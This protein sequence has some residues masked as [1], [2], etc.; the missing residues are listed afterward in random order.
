MR[1]WSRSRLLAST[2]AVAVLLPAGPTVVANARSDGQSPSVINVEIILDSSGSMAQKIGTETR[3]QISKR[4][5]KRVVSA[6]PDRPGIN[7]GFR[8]YGHLGDNSS[9]GRPVSCRSSDLMVPVDGVDKVA[10]GREVDLARP[11]GWTPLAYS[12][13]RAG[14]DL[15][16]GGDG[17]VNAAVLVTD[18]LE[19]CGGDPCAV[20]AALHASDVQLVTHVVSFAVD[21]AERAT[22]QC[23]ADAGGGLLLG[24]Q[25]ADQLTGALFRILQDLDVVSLTGTLEIESVDGIWPDA[26]AVCAGPL[27]DSDPSGRPITVRFDQTNVAEV[28]VG[29]C[30]VTWREPSGDVSRVRVTVDADRLTRIRGA[31]LAFPQGAGERYVVG[32]A[33]SRVRAWDGPIE[34]GDRVWV[35]PG[36]YVVQLTPLTGDP[37][38]IRAE[39]NVIGGT[40]VR[41][42]AGTEP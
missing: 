23:I 4:V 32:A 42:H 29:Q 41:L 17:V 22:L 3:M 33:G 20:A 30:S 16:P 21:P 34:S 2:L 39:V 31:L 14:Q 37:I 19:T 7:V 15:P 1:A 9:A 27:T 26:T 18:G 35:R 40:V 8:I 10:I 24:A 28:P 13:G 11:T 6:I 5:L 12:L 38:L 25:N 36:R